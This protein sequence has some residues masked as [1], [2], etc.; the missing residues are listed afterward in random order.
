LFQRKALIGSPAV[1]LSKILSN[2]A[3]NRGSASCPPPVSRIRPSPA[4]VSFPRR[5]N[6]P[7]ALVIVLRDIPVS[8]D[9]RLT[10]PRPWSKA[11]SA[12]YNRAGYSF[13]VLRTLSQ[14]LSFGVGHLDRVIHLT[15]PEFPRF[16]CLSAAP[17]LV[18]GG[19]V[20]AIPLTPDNRPRSSR[21]HA[22]YFR[23]LLFCPTIRPEATTG[24][25]AK[26]AFASLPRS[27]ERTRGKRLLE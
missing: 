24:L 19:D 12:R 1:V 22:V 25:H 8:F 23:L 3:C 4:S 17:Y 7:A 13:S 27:F 21:M 11:L 6:S 26:N 10:S 15:V 14:R 20:I 18:A 5:F 9:S 16:V 2:S